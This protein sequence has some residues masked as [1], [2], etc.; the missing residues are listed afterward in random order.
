MFS[1]DGDGLAKLLGVIG[2]LPCMPRL[3]ERR[4]PRAELFDGI[5]GLPAPLLV[6]PKKRPAKRLGLYSGEKYRGH[7]HMLC[8]RDGKR[9]AKRMRSLAEPSDAQKRVL[10]SWYN[11]DKL[12]C[13]DK[14]GVD[15]GDDDRHAGR[16]ADQY[17]FSVCILNAFRGLGRSSK[18]DRDGV[19]GSHRQMEVTCTIAACAMESQRSWI[20]DQ[21]AS[22][23]SRAR[24]FFFQRYYDGTSNRMAC[25]ALQGKLEK[26]AR[27][28]VWDQSAEQWKL[29]GFDEYTSKG[30]CARHGILNLMAMG[31]T[32]HW[33]DSAGMSH[34]VRFLL[35]PTVLEDG[36]AGTIYSAVDFALPE[37]S[38]DGLQALADKVPYCFLN[39]QPDG[40]AA[41]IRK[42]ILSLQRLARNA[43]SFSEA[44][45][46]AHQTWR[47]A[48]NRYAGV[49]GDLYAVHVTCGHVQH[50]NRLAAELE[51]HIRDPLLGQ[52]WVL[53]PPDPSWRVHNEGVLLRTY[54]KRERFVEAANDFDDDDGVCLLSSPSAQN[55]LNH[56]NAP[57]WKSRFGH[58]CNGCCS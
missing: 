26:A 20:A 6:T 35:P 3:D 41:N 27:Y 50:S 19:S 23:A 7:D 55:L 52:E 13:G 15:D 54:L 16:T 32:L 5:D 8:M 38:P 34:D 42:I 10:E 17:D 53:A 9:D 57:W 18:V 40:C 49:I 4:L 43:I 31:G 12:R 58:W 39:E 51:R 2:K 36:C 44:T 56:C 48:A 33:T 28:S 22:I 30:K 25:G 24:P 37:L 29:V 45:C 47:I 21:I 1:L 14:V 11:R 46:A